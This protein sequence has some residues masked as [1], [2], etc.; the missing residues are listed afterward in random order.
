MA[1]FVIEAVEAMAM[2]SFRVN[3]HSGGLPQYPP[4][5]MLALLIYCYANGIFLESPGR[6][7]NVPGHR[8]ALRVRQHPPG[9]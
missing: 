6:T 5:M 1:H 4:R 7:G 2:E 3:P 8:G 9:P